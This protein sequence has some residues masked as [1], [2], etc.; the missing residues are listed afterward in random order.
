MRTVNTETIIEMRTELVDF[1]RSLLKAL[2]TG[3]ALPTVNAK[4]ILEKYIVKSTKELVQYMSLA[5]SRRMSRD[6]L[7]ANMEDIIK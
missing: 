7:T 4:D 3:S 1:K 5:Q 2:E 6:T